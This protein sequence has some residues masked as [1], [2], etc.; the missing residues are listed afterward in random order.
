MALEAR[1]L[2]MKMTHVARSAVPRRCGGTAADRVNADVGHRKV[3]QFEF[4][5]V[6]SIEMA[7]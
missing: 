6:F 7:R 4:A 5:D 2:D 3:R 1:A